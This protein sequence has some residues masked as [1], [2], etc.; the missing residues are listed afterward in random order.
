MSQNLWRNAKSIGNICLPK[1]AKSL[2]LLVRATLAFMESVPQKIVFYSFIV[3]HPCNIMTQN[4]STSV[5]Y[6][7]NQ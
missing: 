5:T 7:H 1:V 4:H 2:L 3:R 6:P